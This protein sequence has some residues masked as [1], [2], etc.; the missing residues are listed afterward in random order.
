MKN[1]KNIKKPFVFLKKV[2][3]QKNVTKIISLEAA[4]FWKI[5][6]LKNFFKFAGKYLRQSLFLIKLQAEKNAKF[7]KKTTVLK[8]F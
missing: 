6:V 3:L 2:F 1:I 8:F 7:N 4:L 5:T